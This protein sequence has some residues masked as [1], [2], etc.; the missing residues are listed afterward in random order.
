MVQTDHLFFFLSV[1]P[2]KAG[3]NVF[4]E[5][6]EPL[7]ISVR[8]MAIEFMTVALKSFSMEGNTMKKKNSLV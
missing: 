3:S 7:W 2:P 5:K 4:T 1:H 8:S 6:Q